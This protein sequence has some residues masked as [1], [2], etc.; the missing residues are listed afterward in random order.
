MMGLSIH[1][2]VIRKL[3]TRLF[4]IDLLTAQ[5]I[6]TGIVIRGD[7]GLGGGVGVVV[8]V[9]G[10]IWCIYYSVRLIYF[11]GLLAHNS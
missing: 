11:Y 10:R 5:E 8:C 2:T 9:F 4:Y 1:L 3:Y 6:P 7:W